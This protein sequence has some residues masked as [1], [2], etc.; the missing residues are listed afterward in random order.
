MQRLIITNGSSAA[1][2][3]RAA[4]IG[5][6]ILTWDDVLYEGPVPGSRTLESLS[7]VRAEYISNCGWGNYDA[8]R[9]KFR[10][11]DHRFAEALNSLHTDETETVLWFEHD[12]Y[13][14]LQMVQILSLLLE[15]NVDERRIA[16]ICHD[17]FVAQSSSETLVEDFEKRERVTSI[18]VEA[19]ALIWKA[20]TATSPATLVELLKISDTTG[21]PYLRHALRRWFAEFPDAS[22]GLTRTERTI[23]NC[24]RARAMKGGEL[25]RCQQSTE[26][27]AFMGDASF[28]MV[29]G[30]MT[31]DGRELIEKVRPA[32]PTDI[33]SRDV[34]YALTKSALRVLENKNTDTA[35]ARIQ[36]KWMG[37]VRLTGDNPW[38]WNAKRNK[39]QTSADFTKMTGQ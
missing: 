12:L 24:L 9:D 30:R 21:L 11:R 5:D 16:L 39:F 10:Q 2:A 26:E 37:G 19:A 36:E 28:W 15:I 14:Q 1:H 38:Y 3:I 18:Q 13:D 31:A 32:S 35:V 22:D 6:E 25:F 17:H 33:D 23:L 4:G 7:D 29:L 20:F 8:V 27:A 34:K